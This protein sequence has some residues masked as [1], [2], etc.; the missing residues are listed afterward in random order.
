[1][2]SLIADLEQTA[3]FYMKQAKEHAYCAVTGNP[4][5][6]AQ[7]EKEVSEYRIRYNELMLVICKLKNFKKG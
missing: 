1:M 3:N 6:R 5:S 7:N 4:T 2:E